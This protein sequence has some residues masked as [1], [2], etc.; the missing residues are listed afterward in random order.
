MYCHKDGALTHTEQQAIKGPKIIGE[1]PFK[2]E[3]NGKIYIKK[4]KNEKQETRI[5]YIDIQQ[6]LYIRFLT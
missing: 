5:N 4:K 1:K 6:L 3:T 2:R